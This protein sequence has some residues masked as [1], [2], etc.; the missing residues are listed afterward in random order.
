LGAPNASFAVADFQKWRPEG[1][2]DAIVFN[3][4]LYYAARPCDVARR[5]AH[6]LAPEGRLI[7][8][9]VE[10]GDMSS[11][12]RKLESAF[13]VRGE[14]SVSNQR[15]QRWTIKALSPKAAR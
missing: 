10:Y 13:E 8:S 12:W 15:G 5:Y 6:N 1:R 14:R 11:M 3:E 2:Y 7:V 9:A 4:S